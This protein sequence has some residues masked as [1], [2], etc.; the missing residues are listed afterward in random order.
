MTKKLSKLIALFLCCILLIVTFSGCIEKEQKPGAEGLLAPEIKLDQSSILPD[1]KDGAYHDYDGTMLMLKDFSYKFPDLVD[2]FSIGE[3]VLGR[4]IWCIRITNE[5]N[6]SEA[7]LSCLIDGCIHGVEWEAGEACLYLSEYLLINFD[8]NKTV[9]DILNNSEIYL[10][11]LVNPDGRQN[12]EVG[13]DN[14]VDLNRNF[15]VFFGRLR[16]RCFRLGKLF[17][18][19]KIPIIKIRPNDPSKWWRNCGRFAFSEPESRALR[20]FMKSLNYHDFSFYVDCHTAWHDIM[21]PVPWAKTILFPPYIISEREE[22][23]FDYVKDW[24][25]ANTEYEAD[26]S[27][28]NKVGGCADYWCFKEF[29]IPAFTFEILSIDYDAWYGEKKHDN[30]VH[31]MK[32]TL[33]V[34][35][36]LLLNIE[37]LHDWKIPDIQPPLPEG[38]P[39]PPLQKSFFTSLKRDLILKSKSFSPCTFFLT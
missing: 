1:W 11:P 7:K 34:F 28:Y 15:D 23:I 36:Y 4:N 16:S 20:D 14:G 6:N 3:S 37:N 10:I 2:I 32:T 35:L 25:E 39:P 5:K 22:K 33:P 26:R 8:T 13:N 21:T 27:K 12:D 30:L 17:G 31:W 19:I 18:K 29:C 24:V 9:T 38:V